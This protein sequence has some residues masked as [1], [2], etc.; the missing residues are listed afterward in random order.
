MLLG[1]MS[2][3]M[4]FGFLTIR[5]ILRVY[6]QRHKLTFYYVFNGGPFDRR[7]KFYYYLEFLHFRG[8]HRKKA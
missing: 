8:L 4:Q 1:M 6:N 7:A 3:G 2:C 5:I